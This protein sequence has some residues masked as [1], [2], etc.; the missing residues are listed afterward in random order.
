M[1]ISH[2]YLIIQKSEYFLGCFDLYF[3]ISVYRI[4]FLQYLIMLLNVNNGPVM[5]LF[6]AVTCSLPSGCILPAVQLEQNYRHL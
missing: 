6:V 3:H 4:V 1:Y 5:I 2:K